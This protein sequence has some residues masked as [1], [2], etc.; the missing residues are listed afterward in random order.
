MLVLPIL[1]LQS[2]FSEALRQV[3]KQYENVIF[4]NWGPK[5]MLHNLLSAR[6]VIQQLLHPN[7]DSDRYFLKRAAHF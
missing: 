6:F 7:A 2:A 4:W 3:K 1:G 5:T